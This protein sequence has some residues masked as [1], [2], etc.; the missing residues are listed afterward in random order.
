MVAFL[1]VGATCPEW[2]PQLGLSFP[3]NAHGG[4]VQLQ[5]LLV[6]AYTVDDAHPASLLL[7]GV[8][9]ADKSVIPVGAFN[10]GRDNSYFAL[11]QDGDTGACVNEAVDGGVTFFSVSR[12]DGGH[13]TA[14]DTTGHVPHVG[15]H[16]CHVVFSGGA[17]SPVFVANYAGETN[18]GTV[19]VCARSV[20]APL[21]VVG[22]GDGSHAHQVVLH[23]RVSNVALATDLGRDAVTVYHVV[24]GAGA[25]TLVPS[26]ASLSFP[27]GTGPRHMAFHP[28]LPVLYVLGELGNTLSVRVLCPPRFYCVSSALPPPPFPSL[29]FPSLP[30]KC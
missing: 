28:S 9:A 3:R 2:G 14:I 5:Q 10:C 18:K 17:D 30:F 16:P 1:C 8:D 4:C 22:F 6:G 7:L 24:Q 13:V 27:P 20:G 21:Q 19:A 15:E 25:G 12:D 23:P 29:P 11:T 26:G